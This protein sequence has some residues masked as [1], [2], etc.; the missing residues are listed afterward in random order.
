MSKSRDEETTLPQLLPG[1]MIQFQACF[2]RERGGHAEDPWQLP[3][4]V[5][6]RVVVEFIH[7]EAVWMGLARMVA[8]VKHEHIDLTILKKKSG[9]V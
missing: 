1:R 7:D 5:W 3:L 6:R 4:Q 9:L 8:L 2:C